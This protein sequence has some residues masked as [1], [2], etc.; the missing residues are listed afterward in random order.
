MTYTLHMTMGPTVTLT[1]HA[2]MNCELSILANSKV[3]NW[4]FMPTLL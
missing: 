2:W 1:S 3:Q 4:V